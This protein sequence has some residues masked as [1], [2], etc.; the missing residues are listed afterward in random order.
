M[1]I[2]IYE[3]GWNNFN[4][5]VFGIIMSDG[6]LKW[7]GR[8]KNRLAIRICLNDKKIIELL[9]EKMCIGNRVYL[10]GKNYS[11]KYRNEDAIKFL[12]RYG[13]TERKSLTMK[14]PKD[15]PKQFIPSF[16][17]GY[18]DGDGSIVL[19]NTIYNLYGQV[20]F[21]S[22]SLDFLQELQVVL[23]DCNIDSKIYFDNRENNNG[24]YLRIIKREEIEKYFNFIYQNSNIHLSRKYDKFV[25]LITHPKKYKIS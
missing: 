20:S 12:I 21:T 10:Q 19:H 5:Y 22:G 2:N 16:I 15:I 7:E 25:T 18:F 6:C 9:H 17:R 13:L 3:D 24:K 1:D 8:N 11:I 4:A 14:F 23:R